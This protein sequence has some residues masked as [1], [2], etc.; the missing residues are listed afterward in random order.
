MILQ[1]QHLRLVKMYISLHLFHH[2]EYVF[3]FFDIVRSQTSNK[4]STELN[5]C[6]S[7]LFRQVHSNS[8]EV[9]IL[10]AVTK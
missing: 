4:K 1:H 5:K 8:K 9:A 7:T 2:L 10:P 6:R 3:N